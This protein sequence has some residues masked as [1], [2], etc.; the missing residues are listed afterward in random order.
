[1]YK[2]YMNN[3]GYLFED[4]GVPLV[5]PLLPFLL[6]HIFFRIG[7]Y[8]QIGN[9]IFKRLNFFFILKCVHSLTHCSAAF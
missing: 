9:Y 2:S 4:L 3:A 7:A 1:M 5:P 6:A 8:E